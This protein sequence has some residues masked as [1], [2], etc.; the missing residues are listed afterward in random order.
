MTMLEK[1]E[2]KVKKMPQ[3]KVIKAT[4]S[5][6][7]LT[8]NESL[9]Q[10]LTISWQWV[11][12]KVSEALIAKNALEVLKLLF[13]ELDYVQLNRNAV[14]DIRSLVRQPVDENVLREIETKL[15]SLKKL[16]GEYLKHPQINAPQLNY[17]IYESSF[18]VQQL[19]SLDIVGVGAFM[20]A[21]GFRLA[22]LLEQAASN[23]TAWSQIKDTAIDDCNYAFRV[24][25]KLFRLSVGLID[26]SC[27]CI[28]WES[29]LEIEESI[30]Q[31]ECRYFDGKD[32]HLFRASRAI[33]EFECNKHRLLM[34]ET[35]ADRVNQTAAKPVRTAVKKWRELAASL[36]IIYKH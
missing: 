34:F 4:N 14:E 26:K 23:R 3:P 21:S 16:I 1:L 30:T 29:E 8:L 12:A 24:T 35:V 18:L 36:Q 7:A 15:D 32:I 2:E 5:R 13:S 33:A 25:P 31:Y 27:Q 22:L 19:K 11:L 10:N 9:P 17:L 28:R 6:G 20:L